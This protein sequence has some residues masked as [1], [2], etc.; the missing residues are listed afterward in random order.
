MPR[1]NKH[2]AQRSISLCVN[3]SGHGR[4]ELNKGGKRAN[5]VS[6]LSQNGIVREIGHGGLEGAMMKD[7]LGASVCRCGALL[8][9]LALCGIA[10]G[11]TACGG[12]PTPA[13]VQ[14]RWGADCSSPFIEIDNG[15]IHV[16]PDD[17]DYSLNSVAFDGKTLILKYDLLSGPVSETYIFSGGSL[18]LDR[19]N[20]PGMDAVWHKQPMQKC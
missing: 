15:K 1:R 13:A 12:T 20:Y 18:R 11:L 10:V 7:K 16:F 17:A 14:G 9:V 2:I 5:P 4:L 19:G 3:R 6:G 8:H